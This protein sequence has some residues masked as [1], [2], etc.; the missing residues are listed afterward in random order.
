MGRDHDLFNV[1]PP[2]QRVQLVAAGEQQNH[3]DGGAD[4]DPVRQSERDRAEQIGVD[5]NEGMT[6]PTFGSPVSSCWPTWWR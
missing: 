6:S 4:R 3:G 5:V 2:R 1:E